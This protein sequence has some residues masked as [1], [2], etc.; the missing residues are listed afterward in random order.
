M[1]TFFKTSLIAIAF[2][3][4]GC[5]GA[6]NE[7]IYSKKGIAVDGYDLVS[8]F[9][10]KPLE[11]NDQFTVVYEGATYHFTTAEHRDTF[12][13]SPEK[14][15]PEYGGF[16]A[17]AIATDNKKVK[18]DPE[19]YEIRDG[20]LYLFYNAWGVNTLDKWL[21][22]DPKSLQTKADANWSGL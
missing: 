6:Q 2:L 19:T 12:K 21:E 10:D 5:A 9:N 7:N 18:I 4:A 13:A 16:C 17:Y 3:I 11:G 8:Y 15:L 1:K 20:K 14:F 22:E